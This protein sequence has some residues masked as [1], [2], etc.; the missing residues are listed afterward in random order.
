MV[1]DSIGQ[2][3]IAGLKLLFGDRLA[4]AGINEATATAMIEKAVAKALP[5]AIAEADEVIRREID[6]LKLSVAFDHL[7]S[8]LRD[9]D[10]WFKPKDLGIPKLDLPVFDT[11]D[12]PSK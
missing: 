9:T 10:D 5:A 4:K 12:S 7:D 1:T 3:L 11:S 6:T 8:L 2:I